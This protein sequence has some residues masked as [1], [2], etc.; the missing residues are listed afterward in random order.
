MAFRNYLSVSLFSLCAF[1]PSA[2]LHAQ[3]QPDFHSIDTIVQQGIEEK[4]FPGAVVIVGHGGQIVFHR[5]YGYKSHSPDEPMSENTVFDVASLTKVLA[6]APSVMQLYQQGAFLL[7][8]PVSKYLPDF[9]VNGKQD[10]T[11]RQLLTHYSGLPPDVALDDVWEG[12]QEGLRRAFTS[13]PVTAAGVQFRYSDINFITLGALVEKLSGM[14]LDE[15]FAKNVAQPLGLTSSRFL[16]PSSWRQRIAP[17]QY[18]HGVMLRGVVHDPTSR[19]MGGVAG[20]AGLFSTAGDVAIYAQ[21][22]L[23]CLAGRPNQFPLRRLTLEKMTIPEQPANAVAMRGLGWDID[24]PFSSNRGELFPVGSFGHTG[25]TGTSVWIDPSSDTYVVMMTNAVYPNGPSGITPIRAAVATVAAQALGI[26]D[27]H[28]AL[29]AKLTGYNESLAGMRHRPDRNGAVL[30]GIDVLEADHFSQLAAMAV[31]HGGHLRIGLLTNQSGLDANGKRTIDI[32]QKDAKAAVPGLELKT[33]FSPEHGISGTEDKEGINNTVDSASGIPVISLYGK[34]KEE[35]RPSQQALR[36][37]DA[38]LIDIQDAGVRFYT[39]DTVVR[40]FLEA[41]GQSGTE[42]V[43]LDRPNPI[44]G[45]FVQGPL[46]DVGKESYVNFAPVP[47]RHGMTIGELARF[48]NGEYQLHAP[49]NVIAMQGWQRG[50]WFDATG[51]AWVNPSPNLRSLQAEI[52]YPGTGLIETSNISVGRGTD[53]PF[54]FVGAPWIDA[55][56]LAYALNARFLPGIRFVPVSFTPQSPYPYANQLCHGVNLVV[57]DRNVLDAPELG[58]EIAWQLHKL[59]PND[60]HLDKID[61]L[62]ANQSVLHDLEE[63]R[64]PQRT[65]EDWQPSLQEFLTKRKPYLLY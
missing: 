10:I 54:E 31:K 25:F 65:D 64:D 52:L 6:T 46:S 13:V 56:A 20:H 58:L 47:S 44:G 17:T 45:S 34:T 15:Y 63:G 61:T 42:I 1:V 40:Y 48:M 51:L 24:T 33:L 49:L 12:K 5:A 19:R 55:R 9:A 43:V 3:S 4:K 62:L 53:T 36:Q 18:D 23:D 41:A 29:G 27:D 50:D 37:L 22:L 39:Y 57:T 30:T 14:T 59:Y 60:Y 11:I 7:N 38:V 8:D 32:L 35:R 2:L 21:N 26:A 28:G 16:P